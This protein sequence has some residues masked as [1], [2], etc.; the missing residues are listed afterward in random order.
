MFTPRYTL[1]NRVL[2]AVTSRNRRPTIRRRILRLVADPGAVLI[3]AAGLGEI[4]RGADETLVARD[5]LGWLS[6]YTA[7]GD[8][9]T[10]MPGA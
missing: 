1:A 6:T 4:D 10:E 2:L 3:L 8:M 9:P 7:T 5:V